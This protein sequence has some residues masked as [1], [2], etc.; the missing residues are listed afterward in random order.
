MDRKQFNSIYN[1]A[2]T[3]YN[4]IDTF[5]KGQCLFNLFNLYL[6]EE[7]WFR[8]LIGTNKDCFYN[9]NNIDKFLTEIKLHLND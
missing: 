3:D 8:D 5:R 1:Q 6:Y 9:D 7:Q 2:I 4:T